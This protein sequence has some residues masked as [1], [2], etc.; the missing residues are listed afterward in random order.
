MW[1][2][3]NNWEVVRHATINAYISKAYYYEASRHTTRNYYEASRPA[4]RNRRGE[5]GKWEAEEA[6]SFEAL[7]T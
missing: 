3:V 6:H 1:Q 2:L 4:S 5:R 7:I